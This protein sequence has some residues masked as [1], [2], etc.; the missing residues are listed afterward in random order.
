MVSSPL[1]GPSDSQADGVA[2]D[3][4]IDDFRKLLNH[5][6]TATDW[7]FHPS[8]R[9]V[10]LA[11]GMTPNPENHPIRVLGHNWIGREAGRR[12][13][14]LIGLRQTALENGFGAAM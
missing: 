8:D 10:P 4:H 5:H 14:P 1:P 9:T 6:L 3:L 7:K 11:P 2:P 13:D 12:L